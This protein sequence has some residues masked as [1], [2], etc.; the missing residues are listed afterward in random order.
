MWQSVC[1]LL[2]LLMS[3]ILLVFVFKCLVTGIYRGLFLA[4]LVHHE[5][6]IL[7]TGDDVVPMIDVNTEFSPA[8][9]STDL[10][11]LMKVTHSNACL[12][13]SLQRVYITHLY[14]ASVWIS[15]L[16]SY[17]QYTLPYFSR[18]VNIAREHGRH[19]LAPV[20]TAIEIGRRYR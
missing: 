17:A 18:A 2:R 15:R 1:K 14:S 7:V 9:L 3:R 5:G 6:R 20:N 10:Y 19:F 11:W 16:M 12:P 8:T 4:A 13:Y